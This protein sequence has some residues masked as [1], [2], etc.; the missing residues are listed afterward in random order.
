MSVPV[1]SAD[2]KPLMPCKER[3]AR[4]L[5]SRGEAKPY[6]QKSIFCIKLTR[7]ETEKR[8]EYPKVV[9]GIDP[10]SKRE[11]YTVASE[12]GVVLN[13][14]T[15]TPNWVKS[16]IEAKRKKFKEEKEI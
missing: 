4:C 14:T 9:L 7:K 8:E 3:R 13:I 12:K 10:G 15:N 2:G 6:W 1:I 5:M 11:G 16:H